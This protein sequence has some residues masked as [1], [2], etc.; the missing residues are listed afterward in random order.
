[1]QMI[2]LETSSNNHDEDEVL[3]KKALEMVHE[4][5]ENQQGKDDFLDDWYDLAAR[6]V[7]ERHKRN[8]LDSNID[9][10]IVEDVVW[11]FLQ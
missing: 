6:R 2:N 4:E 11:A 1:M 10:E 5:V 3:F 9:N 8:N 7:I